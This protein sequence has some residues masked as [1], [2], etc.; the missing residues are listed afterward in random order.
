MALSPEDFQ[1]MQETL[2]EL[3]GRNYSLEE[4]SRKQK[5]A[6]GEAEAKVK[7]L[8]QELTKAT[9]VIEK[10]KKISEVQRLMHD[11]D[12]AGRKLISQEEDW[13]LQ[14]QT[15]LEELQKLVLRNEELEAEQEKVGKRQLE[16]I[17]DEFSM[18]DDEDESGRDWRGEAKEAS[19][20]LQEERQ[21]VAELRVIK[22]QL[23]QKQELLE[24]EME[25]SRRE[26]KTQAE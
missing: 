14:N 7:V 15:L 4:Q 8:D 20:R 12:V 16:R 19:R 24:A 9:R 3:K 23:K 26:K 11:N 13:R 6:L 10:S 17:T 22:E 18:E 25:A 5:N 2:L 21:E 1:R